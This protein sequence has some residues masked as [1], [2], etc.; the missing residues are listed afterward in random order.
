MTGI[1]KMIQTLLLNT[2]VR[3]VSVKKESPRKK[4]SEDFKIK[5]TSP[6]RCDLT[7]TAGVLEN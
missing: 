7:D 2:Q 4:S 1:E 3:G 6:L 5:W